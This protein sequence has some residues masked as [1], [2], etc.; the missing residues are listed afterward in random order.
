[1]MAG[2]L[3]GKGA[4]VTGAGGERGM[5]RAIAIA[6]AAEGAKVVVNDFGRDKDGNPAADRV[7]KDIKK[8]GGTAV[9]N[10]DSV[11]S[12]PGGKNI[13]KT[14]IDNFGRIDILVNCAGNIC[15]VPF[16]EMTE[17]QWDS[18]INV[19]IKGHFACTQA[20]A[21]YM[22]TQKS[23]RIINFSS[24]G[25]FPTGGQRPSGVPA[26]PGNPAYGTAKAGIMGF[27]TS[28]SNS[29]KPFNITVNCIIPSADTGL[30]PG[31]GPRGGG[32]LPDTLDLGA[33]YVAPMVAYL[34]SDEAK[35]ITGKFIY[36]AGG[37]FCIYAQPLEPRTFVRKEGK[38][39]IDELSRVV[40]PLMRLG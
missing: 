8:A 14:A 35:D 30:F 12:V 5:G 38:W 11:A 25:A 22:M 15:P 40:P 28:L 26:S 20:A 27:T 19:H 23:G 16:E 9:A 7:V 4:V 31:T 39:T 1:M 10:Y 6:L 24:R 18:I 37:D 13:I 17:E 34:S 3:V 32:V 36:V 21:R 2:R 33:E 29:L